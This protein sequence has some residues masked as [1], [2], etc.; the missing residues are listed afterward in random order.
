[1]A[2]DPKKV[3]VGPGTLYIAPVGSTEPTDLTAAWAAAWV[4]L[5]YTEAGSTFSFE[6]T[7]EDVP[8]AEEM[9][10]VA[11]LQTARNISVS[12]AAAEMT[13]ANLETALNGGT[14]TVT[15]VAGSEIVTF[16]PPAAGDFTYVA[17]GWQSTDGLERWVFRKGIQTGT[18]DIA[19]QKAP[20]KALI[21]MNFRF[22]KPS[23]Q[24][25]FKF[26]HDQNY[27]VGS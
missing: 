10:P 3:R 1:M 2:G 20:N 21:P 18:V 14:L 7:F 23:G 11:I 9:D 19:R 22:V 16:E 27:T 6:N 13:A 5:G 24:A 8:V 26:I 4:E 25:P 17:L 15:G 12:F